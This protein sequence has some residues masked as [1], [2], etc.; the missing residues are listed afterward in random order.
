[1]AVTVTINGINRSGNVDAGSISWRLKLGQRNG[2]NLSMADPA[3][4]I[5]PVKGHSIV[6]DVDGTPV[7]GGSIDEVSEKRQIPG[8]PQWDLLCVSYEQRIDKQTFRESIGRMFFTVNT[9]T[10]IFTSDAVDA[11]QNDYAVM[12]GTD[13]TLPTPLSASQIYYWKRLSATTGQLANSAGGAAVNITSVGSGNHYLIWMSGSIVKYLW[14]TYISSSEGI[15][16]GT[17]GVGVPVTLIT[18][19]DERRFEVFDNL[20]KAS[21]YVTFVRPDA[22][23]EFVPRTTFTCPITFDAPDILSNRQAGFPTFRSTRQDYANRI[24]AKTD[25]TVL[26]ALSIPGNGT[27]RQFFSSTPIGRLVSANGGT[28]A[29]YGSGEV[30]DWYYIPGDHWVIQAAG[31]T[32]IPG[33]SN[34]D[35]SF[36]SFYPQTVIS[37]DTSAQSARATVEGGTGIYEHPIEASGLDAVGAQTL[38]DSELIARKTDAVELTFWTDSHGCQPGQV[39]NVNRPDFGINT[40][41]LLDEVSAQDIG[42]AYIRYTVRALSGTRLGDWFTTWKQFLASGGGSSSSVASAGGGG[43]G[44][45]TF[46]TQDVALVAAPGTTTISSTATPADGASL[47]LDITQSSS[48]GRQI[49][50]SAQFHSSVPVNI[51][52]GPN[53]MTRMF[54]VAKSDNLWHFVSQSG[55]L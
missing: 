2:A 33:G 52:M 14:N 35:I 43:G 11:L 55:L 34:L 12:V 41:F 10:E 27:K 49:A 18:L 22:V 4:L 21:D 40:D 46:N 51:A 30:A 47:L 42:L 15:T 17:V 7:F 13:G 23:F 45:G 25:G 5:R 28:I 39:L 9:S 48:G 44:G 20:A 31:G 37:E 16:L 29:I 53:E 26:T 6:I 32:V 8:L 1:M 36:E 19:L 24:I 38:A 50:W 54:L 3:D